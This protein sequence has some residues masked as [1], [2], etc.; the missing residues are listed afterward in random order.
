M[1]NTSHI[2]CGG[3]ELVVDVVVVVVVIEPLVIFLS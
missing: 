3:V 1:P 2:Q